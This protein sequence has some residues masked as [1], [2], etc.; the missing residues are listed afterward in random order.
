MEICRLAGLMSSFKPVFTQ[1]V[2][3]PAPTFAVLATHSTVSPT[4]LL[5]AINN[6]PL[7]IFSLH[8]SLSLYFLLNVSVSSIFSHLYNSLLM[9][10]NRGF[11]QDPLFIPNLF[12]N[13]SVDKQT[14]GA[15]PPEP[16]TRYES[17]LTVSNPNG[18]NAF[19]LPQRSK[20]SHQLEIS[21]HSHR[22]AW[23]GTVHSKIKHRA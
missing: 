7:S 13:G 14:S 9:Q 8:I 3:E 6:R 19:F 18:E 12:G 23:H 10:S 15:N 2:I 4:V 1:S 5:M 16:N 17:P 11:P 20:A 21:A 22:M